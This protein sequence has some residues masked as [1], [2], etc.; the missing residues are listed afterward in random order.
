MAFCQASRSRNEAIRA[1]AHLR[2]QP[3]NLGKN[4]IVN[5]RCLGKNCEAS[6]S[7]RRFPPALRASNKTR[8]SI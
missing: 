5:R 8:H 2:Q 3:Y 7:R 6:F 1:T 4:S